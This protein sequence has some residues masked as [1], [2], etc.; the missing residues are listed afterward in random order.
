MGIKSTSQLVLGFFGLTSEK[1]PEYRVNLFKQIHEIVFHGNGGYS[2]NDIYNM[3]RWLRLFTFKEIETYYK[4]QS[5]EVKNSNSSP[6]SSTLIG[7]DG[8]INKSA[9][10]TLNTAK[11]K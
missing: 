9:F 2:W 3:P 5:D 4:K 8:K 1:A 10:P 11:Y 6:G 7:P